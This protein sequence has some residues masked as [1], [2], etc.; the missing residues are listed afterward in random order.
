[1]A[2]WADYTRL[3]GQLNDI[4]RD[5]TEATTQQ[6]RTRQTLA[7]T[8]GQLQQRLASQNQRLQRLAKVLGRPIGSPPPTFT[9]ITDAAQA[10]QLARQYTDTA[11]AATRQLEQLAEQPRLFPGMSPI[12]RNLLVYGACALLAV[13]AEY[14]LLVVSDAAHLD[15][16]TLLAWICTGFPAMAWIGGYL[17][18]SVW[19]RP[20]L[21]DPTVVR[22]PKLGFA[23]CFLAMPAAFCAFKV[24]TSMLGP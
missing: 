14:A 1:M 6:T 16:I 3:T 24:I 19:A 15:A 2:T 21:G 13:L 9:G 12:G 7:E 18:I 17:I 5:Q 23:V 20:H 11:D 4:V 8:V 10:L 22:N